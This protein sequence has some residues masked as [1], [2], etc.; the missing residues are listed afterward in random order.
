[1]EFIKYFVNKVIKD[2]PDL[3]AIVGIFI[4]MTAVVVLL[5]LNTLLLKWV[6]QY[7][8]IVVY[9]ST[10]GMV[11]LLEIMT[12]PVVIYV[13]NSFKQFKTEKMHRQIFSAFI[14]GKKGNKND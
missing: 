2:F 7:T 10:I 11:T 3:I 8:D 5:Y 14:S 13:R 1:M 9:D 4:L 12:I 6:V